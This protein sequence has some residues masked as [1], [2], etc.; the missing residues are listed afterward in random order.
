MPPLP[1]PSSDIALSPAS[2]LFRRAS[3]SISSSTAS[4]LS[5]IKRQATTA[6]IPADYSNIN[7]SPNPGTVV[8]IVLGSV[9]GFLFILWL[10]YTLAGGNMAGSSSDVAS[11]IIRERKRS[12][13]RGSSRRGS[14]RRESVEV[15]EVREVRRERPPP[16][17]VDRIVVEERR[18]SRAPPAVVVESSVTS[19]DEVVV[20]EEHSPPRRASSGKRV[21]EVREVRE[22]GYRTVD[23]MA[24]GGGD[25][26]LREVERRGS[27]RSR[28]D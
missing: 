6:I 12:S 4:F 24:Y 3:S 15:R 13:R 9:G 11:V 10:I 28:G 16:V 17:M 8:G 5:Y 25:R 20:I 7:T 26:P 19:E 1:H 23:P 22:S 18:E 27:R 21:K 14:S 2:L